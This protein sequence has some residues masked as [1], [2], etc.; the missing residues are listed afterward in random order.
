MPTPEEIALD[1]I[2]EA[3]ASGATELVLSR[4]GL[5]AL[6]PE[7]GQ[8]TGLQRLNLHGNP[9]TI[10]EQAGYSGPMLSGR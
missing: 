7:I 10:I 8:L 5:T 4:L 1:R 3:A 2:R 9:L 6:P